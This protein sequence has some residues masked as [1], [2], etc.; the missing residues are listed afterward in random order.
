VNIALLVWMGIG[1]MTAALAGPLILGSLWFGVTE[2]GAVWGMLTGFVTF[3]VLHAQV[4]PVSWLLAIGPNPFFCASLGSIAGVT[5][6]VIVA[7]L[8]PGSRP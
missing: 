1:G 2:R 8:W 5:V 7:R 6:T 4:L 3:S